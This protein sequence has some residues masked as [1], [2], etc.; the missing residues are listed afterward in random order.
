MPVVLIE[1]VP[2]LTKS[3]LSLAPRFPSVEFRANVPI[4]AD[5]TVLAA[6]DFPSGPLDSFRW[7]HILSADDF[8]EERDA[9]SKASDD[10]DEPAVKRPGAIE[11]I[12][13]F[14]MFDD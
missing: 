5:V 9:E 4:T 11:E 2:S 3:L 12:D 6:E 7:L 10:D 8:A 14:G 1:T 13:D